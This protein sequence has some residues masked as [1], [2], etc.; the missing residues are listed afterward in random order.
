M[1]ADW[2]KLTPDEKLQRRLDA[3]LSPP[4]TH[5]ASPE[6]EAAYKAR[7]GRIIDAI[8]LKK[9]PD[10][11]PVT[12]SLAFFPAFYA[13]YTP[14]EVMY[15]ADK[16]ID[17][18]TRVN[19]DFTSDCRYPIATFSGKMLELLD[20]KLYN[21]PGH[22]VA[23][24]QPFQYVEG[25]WMKADEYD[26][27]I[28]DP[29]DFWMRSYLPR[30]IGTLEP[31][32][33][34]LPLADMIELPM[35]P[36]NIA[37]YGL[38]EVA[39]ALEKLIEAG[40]AAQEWM[41]K[42]GPADKKLM[43]GLG[44]PSTS[45]G[46]SKAPLDSISD[47]LRG[48]RATMLDMFRQRDKLM[49]ACERFV[50][51]N[52]RL[53]LSGVRMGNPPIVGIPLHKGAD[54]F[55]S[56]EQFKTLY[57]PT[58][59][60][61]VLG[62]IEEGVIPRLFAEGSYNSRLEMITDLPKGKVIWHFDYTDMARAKEIIGDVA[63]LQGNVPV[64]LIA[65]G[66]AEQTTAYC[67]ELIRTAGKGGGFILAGGAGFDQGRPENVHAMVDSVMDYGVYA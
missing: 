10:R 65:T 7:V 62:L 52:I 56:E 53:G 40:R 18:W 50:P 51:L 44:L 32:K 63:C 47:T 60:K 1:D 64:S 25:E 12:P 2:K 16:A 48:T 38:P 24:D 37:R 34:L 57:W 17:A 46:F 26:A 66:T 27:L 23:D 15:D 39:G 30:I 22:G 43:E 67:R 61:V 41:R 20:Y 3:W 59:R 45:S 42:L 29:G 58:L 6:V 21:W 11:V 9:T 28:S 5:F 49:E 54:G 19:N 31:L 33:G 13:G 14:R 36:G 35:T 8:Q 4:D 55:M